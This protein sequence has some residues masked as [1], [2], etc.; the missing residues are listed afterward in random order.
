MT[1]PGSPLVLT[2]D[3]TLMARY[4]TLLDGMMA[5]SQTT[6]TP[7]PLLHHLLAPAAPHPGGQCL[8][9][10]LGLR[11]VEAALV[12]GGAAVGEIVVVDERHLREVMGPATRVVA[13]SAGEPL[14]LG[15]SSTTM[16]A[17][18]GG[19][20]VPQQWLE[21]LLQR[22]SRI[23]AQVAP[24]A[25]VV[26]GG[27]GA[28]QLAADPAG[29]QALGVDH[30]VVGY[31]EGNVA[32]VLL[33]LQHGES[34]PEVITGQG[35][36]PEHIP[37]VRGATTMGVI[38]ISRGC[39]LGCEFCTLGEVPMGHL[40]AET[41]LADAQTNLAAGNTSLCVLS[42]DLLRYGASGVRC[43]PGRLLELL[44]QLRALPGVRL[45]QGDHVNVSSVRQ[46]TEEQ[47]A[48][49]ADLLTGGKPGARPW[50][51]VGV[52][53]AAGELL[54]ANGGRPKMAGLDP[55]QWGAEC[56]EQLRRLC[57]A[58]FMP[59]ASLVMGLPGETPAQIEACRQWLHELTGWP[60][61]VFP[62]LY[63]PIHGEPQSPPPLTPAH[64]QLLRE[65][66]ELNFRGVPKMYWGNQTAAGEGLGKRLLIQLLGQVNVVQ[67]RGLLRRRQREAQ[68]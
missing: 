25:R 5:A 6:T 47:L 19:K 49:V 44:G 52:E 41:I 50:L 62:V 64:W 43:V 29:R 46:Y 8:V 67:W 55:D 61:T 37:P 66:Y 10:P 22:V 40:P 30:V 58:G 63:A 7:S 51:N 26:L 53:T 54:A 39:G 11:R 9:A 16:A 65:A 13:V 31:A 14:G 60:V 59:M 24:Q 48:A 23:R 15:M 56:A 21:R 28:W 45:I 38:E 35:V 3:R 1:P 20:I 33:A 27:P 2:A 12:A 17:V 34:L 57:R 36:S 68:R 32:E 42:E 4:R 18:T